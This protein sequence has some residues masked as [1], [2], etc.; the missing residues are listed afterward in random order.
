[1]LIKMWRGSSSLWSFWK[2]SKVNTVNTWSSLLRSSMP[3][4]TPCTGRMRSPKDQEDL[5]F[6]THKTLWARRTVKKPLSS[7]ELPK[8]L[9]FFLQKTKRRDG[10]FKRREW[11]WP[12]FLYE[13]WKRGGHLKRSLSQNR[14]GCRGAGARGCI[15]DVSFMACDRVL[16]GWCSHFS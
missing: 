11:D 5:W 9:F 1:M 8:L 10:S 15:F 7:L 12:P 3:G 2:L 6:Q 13:V 14:R 4:S 16:S